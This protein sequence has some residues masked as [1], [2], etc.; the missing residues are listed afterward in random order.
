VPAIKSQSQYIST[1]RAARSL[2]VSVSTVKR[3]VDEGILPAEKTAG[4]HRKLLRAEV[5]SMARKGAIPHDDM[6][7]LVLAPN[8]RKSLDLENFRQALHA[9]LIRGDGADVRTLVARAYRDGLPLESLADR[10]ISPVMEKI[11]HQWELAEI[12]VWHEHRST[13]LVAAALFDLHAEIS[14]RAER[15]R[16]IAIGG[17]PEQD[18]YILASLLAQL[19]LLDAGWEAV[20]LGPNTPL[21]SFVKA[22][23]ELR[24]KLIWLSVSHLDDP[25]GFIRQYS[26]LQAAA[27]RCGTAIAVGGRALNEP[28]RSRLLYTSHGDGLA[29]LAAFAK[30]IHP[31]PQRPRRGRPPLKHK[32]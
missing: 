14:R 22:I 32:S 31:R 24:P 11:G 13:L 10:A 27:A 21:E 19:V 3:W 9:A 8:R 18:P 26:A 16:P 5:L 7:E 29:H 4:G 20:N 28:V 30:T 25:A 6:A 2:G 23:G 1:A 17:A 12:E 15:D